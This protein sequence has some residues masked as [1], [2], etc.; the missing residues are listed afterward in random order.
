MRGRGS[1]RHGD[2]Q[3]TE[4]V[5]AFN[6]RAA[7]FPER[8]AIGQRH[9]EAMSVEWLWLLGFSGRNGN[10]PT[11]KLC[12]YFC[13]TEEDRWVSTVTVNQLHQTLL[14]V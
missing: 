7:L 6:R 5:N 1:S 13:Q 14:I 4:V 9:A 8:S 2:G 11:L 10:M 3:R 12:L